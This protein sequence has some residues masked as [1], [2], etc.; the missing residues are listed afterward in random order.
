M[1]G[2]ASGKD[3][4][5]TDDKIKYQLKA[6]LLVTEVN[7]ASWFWETSRR[8]Q[9]LILTL[10]DGEAVP[11]DHCRQEVLCEQ[12]LRW[13]LEWC[14]DVLMRSPLLSEWDPHIIGL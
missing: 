13:E 12:R 14:V 5:F 3:R 9:T 1:E 4:M 10:K 6:K 7:K 8:W 2:S 11:G